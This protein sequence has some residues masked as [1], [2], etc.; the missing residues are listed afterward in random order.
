MKAKILSESHSSAA[1]VIYGAPLAS[2]PLPLLPLLNPLPSPPLP[3][4]SPPL[5]LPSPPL[6]PLPSPPLPSPPL[7][8]PSPPLNPLPLAPLSPLPLPLSNSLGPL[9][10]FSILFNSSANLMKGDGMNCV[11][12]QRSGVS[13]E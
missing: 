3:L 6:N 4:P 5:P 1:G 12:G 11:F 2:P 10:V 7:P 9:L 8:L 13:K